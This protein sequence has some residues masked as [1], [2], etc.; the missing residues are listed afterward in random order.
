MG[1]NNPKP[2]R[3]LLAGAAEAQNR[4]GEMRAF[5]RGAA[6]D[7]PDASHAFAR[8]MLALRLRRSAGGKGPRA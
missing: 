3:R 8:A 4:L 5:G 2:P 7:P 1:G 6:Q